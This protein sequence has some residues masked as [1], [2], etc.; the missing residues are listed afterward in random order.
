MKD[1]AKADLS[2]YKRERDKVERWHADGTQTMGRKKIRA[3]HLKRKCCGTCTNLI[4]RMMQNVTFRFEK[5][6]HFFY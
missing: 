6:T 1:E 2:F 4:V 5:I 3:R